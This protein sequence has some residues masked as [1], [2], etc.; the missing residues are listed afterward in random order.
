MRCTFPQGPVA[1]GSGGEQSLRNNSGNECRQRQ[2]QTQNRGRP[3]TQSHGQEAASR[4][5]PPPW[6]QLG[7]SCQPPTSSYSGSNGEISS[8]KLCCISI[9]AASEIFQHPLPFLF[10]GKHK[11]ALTAIL[12]TNCGTGVVLSAQ[13]LQERGCAHLATGEPHS[14]MC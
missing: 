12:R 9:Q 14:H 3:G 8:L 2:M 7:V 10:A 4:C 13:R 11:S 5:I 6:R 1:R